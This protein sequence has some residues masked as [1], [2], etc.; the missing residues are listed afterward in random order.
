[1]V[2]LVKPCLAVCMLIESRMKHGNKVEGQKEKKKSPLS[3]DK[4]SKN[5]G[6][7]R[8][9]T[10]ETNLT[11]VHEDAGLIPGLA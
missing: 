6:V 4:N 9:G 8:C 3:T 10:V 11:S 2:S 7:P 1:M 5:Q